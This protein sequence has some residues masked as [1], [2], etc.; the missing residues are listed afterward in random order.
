MTSPAYGTR[1][2]RHVGSVQKLCSMVYCPVVEIL[3]TVPSFAAPPNRVVPYRFPLASC[4]SFDCGDVPS[5]HAGCAQKLYSVVSVCARATDTVISTTVI[6]A[7]SVGS[8]RMRYGTNRQKVRSRVIGL[9]PFCVVN[10]QLR[11]LAKSCSVPSP[12]RLCPQGAVR[13]RSARQRNM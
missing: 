2:S 7:I 9:F 3:Y 6:T 11:K 4:T 12:L 1:P 13:N 10:Q 5:V 8:S